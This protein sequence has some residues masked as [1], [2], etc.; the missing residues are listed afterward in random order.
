MNYDIGIIGGGPAGY[1]A[2]LEAANNGLS[3]VIFEKRSPGGVCLYE[4][5]IPTKSLIH[6][7]KTFFYAKKDPTINA[8]ELSFNWEEAKSKKERDVEKL[9][10]GLINQLNRKGIKTIIGN[11]TLVSSNEN[12]VIISSNN[13]EYCVKNAIIATGS[14]NVIPEIKGLTKLMQSGMALDSTAILEHCEPIER[15]AVIGAGV[16]GLEMAS[17][18]ANTGTK[19]SIFEKKQD[20]VNGLDNDTTKEFIRSLKRKGIQIFTG[21]SI[22]EVG[23]DEDGIYVHSENFDNETERYDKLLIAVGRKG[24]IENLGTDKIPS[25]KI[26]NNFIA[27]DNAHKTGDMHIYACGDVCGK[28]SLAYTGGSVGESIIR[29]IVNDKLEIEN[30]IFPTVI[31]TNPEVAFIG[32]AAKECQI[33]AIKYKE[34]S[35]SMNYSS[36]F[37]VENTK[38]N[39][40]FKLIIDESGLIIGCQIIGNGAVELIETV[41]A[42][43]AGKQ[44]IY[45]IMKL[46][47]VH[48][49]KSEI[50]KEAI[51]LLI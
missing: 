29:N 49:S 21:Q 8:K 9:A 3:T 46:S 31:F 50:I 6:S 39:G 42:F 34:V 26:E 32:R 17:L 16:I 45:D 7:T 40:V 44:S 35:C 28:E 24:N 11:A 20:I 14:C 1:H 36:L 15:L 37:V 47:V 23:K 13:T 5:C 18:Y 10:A 38:E 25:I 43:I 48:P 51:K 4:G 41:R 27:T 19:V 12:G 2:A 33:L 30:D 22:S